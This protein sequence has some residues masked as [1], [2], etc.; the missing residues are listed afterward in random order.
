MAEGAAA[1][2]VDTIWNHNSALPCLSLQLYT[3]E[4]HR[5]VLSSGG[6]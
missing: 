4:S 2:R 5:E 3:L 1:Q 6:L